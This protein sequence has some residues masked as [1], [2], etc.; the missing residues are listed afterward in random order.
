MEGKCCIC[1][2]WV[3]SVY[4]SM[5]YY[6]DGEIRRYMGHEKCLG[7]LDKKL[8]DGIDTEYELVRGEYED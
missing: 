8:I 6:S 1:E 4:S 2:E 5:K 3:T 7:E